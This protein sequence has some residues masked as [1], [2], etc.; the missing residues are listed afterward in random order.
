VSE[1][2]GVIAFDPHAVVPAPRRAVETAFAPPQVVVLDGADGRVFEL[3]PSASAV[4]LLI[5]GEH[6]C[7]EI[8]ND[9]SQITGAPADQLLADVANAVDDFASNRLLRSDDH[10]NAVDTANGDGDESGDGDDHRQDRAHRHDH[11]G[12]VH[13]STVLL[14]PPD[15]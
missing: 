2:H 14:P 10:E 4:W 13:S 7:A 6:S 3:S 1:P 12:Q 15:P 8:A 9:L 11:S 5:D